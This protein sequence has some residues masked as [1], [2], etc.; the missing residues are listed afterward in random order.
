MESYE[1]RT[2]VSRWQ[3]SDIGV[4]LYRFI[5]ALSQEYKV[6]PHTGGFNLIVSY[7]IEYSEQHTV[8]KLLLTIDQ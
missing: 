3:I 2:E 6:S 7:M 8:R 1:K 5:T 4:W